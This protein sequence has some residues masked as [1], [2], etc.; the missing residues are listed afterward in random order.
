MRTRKFARDAAELLRKLV[1]CTRGCSISA[2]P[3]SRHLDVL[4][5]SLPF[6]HGSLGWRHKSPVALSKWGG[7]LKPGKEDTHG[8]N[9][10]PEWCV[11]FWPRFGRERWYCLHADRE[12]GF[13]DRQGS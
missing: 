7:N 12:A 4:L 13:G 10:Y 9:N 5:I 6:S 8:E 3:P 1:S 2:L 11:S